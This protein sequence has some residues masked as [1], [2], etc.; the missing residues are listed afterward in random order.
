MYRMGDSATAQRYFKAS[1]EL[2]RACLAKQPDSYACK[3]EL[4]NSLGM[5]AGS[6][7]DL[8]HPK[9]ALALYQEEMAV[10]DSFS[11][12]DANEWDTRRERAGLFA[13]LA[14]V[15]VKLGD[16]AEAQRL[17]D[18]CTELRLQFE[19][20]RPDAWAVKNDLGLSYNN[21][22]SMRFPLGRDAKAAR[23][24]HRKALKVFR[25]RVRGIP[26]DLESKPTLAMTLYYE[27]TCALHLGEKAAADAGY[28]ECL[29]IL[30]EL[31]NEPK[32]KQPQAELMLAL[33]RCGEHAEAAKIA[34][35]LVKTPPKDEG[36][37]VQSACGYALAAAA[38]A[39][40]A[41][42]VQGYTKRAVE[43][44]RA[45]KDRGWK[46]VSRLETDTDLEPIRNDPAFQAVLGEF[47]QLVK[48]AP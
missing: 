6:E 27:A 2:S 23:E 1:L 13:R 35:E 9:E 41:K 25:K 37:Y 19:K 14:E 48:K 40:D 43:C 36:L 10:R 15:N 32:A 42:L 7:L 44:L 21:Q 46:D 29:K 24:V 47:R 18:H 3:S 28:R 11:P 38:A 16:L 4:A 34:G 22:G 5:L 17:Y 30:K 45:A 39:G 20:E 26:L 8:G 12:A 31:A 33:A